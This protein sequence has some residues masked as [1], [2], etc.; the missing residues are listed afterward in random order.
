MAVRFYVLNVDGFPS[1]AAAD[2][3]VAEHFGTFDGAETRA[4][5]LANENPGSLYEIVQTVCGFVCPIEAATRIE[6]EEMS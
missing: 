4:R 3:D 6:P 5:N 1:Y 2:D